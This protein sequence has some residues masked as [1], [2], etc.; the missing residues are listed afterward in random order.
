V[1]YQEARKCF[2]KKYYRAGDLEA[3]V[4]EAVFSLLRGSRKMR[5]HIEERIEE[6]I[7]Q[8]S[9]RDP[10]REA[11]AWAKRLA[12]L[13][14]RLSRAQDLAIDGLVSSEDLREKATRQ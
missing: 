10:E 12:K 2:N 11:K 14:E 8:I 1:S 5:N 7:E 4:R 9:R 6:R 13:D 3:R